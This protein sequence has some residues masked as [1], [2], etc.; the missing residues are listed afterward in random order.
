VAGKSSGEPLIG[1]LEH[2]A[3]K[4]AAT[5]AAKIAFMAFITFHQK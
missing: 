2:P 3:S 4:A 5:A 1:A